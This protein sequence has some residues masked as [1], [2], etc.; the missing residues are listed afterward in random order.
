MSPHNKHQA[1]QRRD[2]TVTVARAAHHTTNTTSTKSA[3]AGNTRRT[4]HRALTVLAAAAA[5]LVCTPVV[6]QADYEQV[7]HFAT[8]GTE[9]PSGDGMAVN[10]TGAGGVEPG[11]LYLS[12]GFFENRVLRYSPAGELKEIWG[13]HTI[14]SGPDLPDQLNTVTVSATSGTYELTAQTGQAHGEFTQGSKIVTGVRTEVGALHV[15]DVIETPTSRVPT[16][17][18]TGNIASGSTTVMAASKIGEWVDGMALYAPG[19]PAGTTVTAVTTG[20]LGSGTLTLSKPATETKIGVSLHGR[21]TIAAVAAGTLE[22]SLPATLSTSSNEY[23]ESP[24][25]ATET[26]API[27]Y[28]ASAA[29]LKAALVALVAFE[30][31]DL[32]VT[33]GLGTEGAALYQLGFEGAYAGSPVPL[34]SAEVTLAGGFPSSSVEI[35][36]PVEASTSGFQ[37]CRLYAGD[38]CTNQSP[39]SRGPDA[40]GF[41]EP[42]GVAVDQKTGYVYVLNKTKRETGGEGEE[43]EHNLIEVFSADGSEV[44]ARFGD[45]A[46]TQNTETDEE[47]EK[48]HGLAARSIAVDES[49][50]VYVGDGGAPYRVM[51]FRPE[52]AGV[53]QEYVY[54]GA[55]HDLYV[56]EVPF[57]LSLD[58]AG[59]LYVSSQEF[60]EE[61][62]LGEPSAPPICTGAPKGDLYAMTVDPMTGELFY[63]NGS[64]N[65]KKIYRLKSCDPA[66]GQFVQ[67]QAPVSTTPSTIGIYALVFNPDLAWASGRPR[68]VLYAVDKERYEEGGVMHNGTG[69]VFAPAEVQAP[70]VVSES[71]SS[72]R[73][74]SAALHGE[75][76][77]DGFTTHYVFQYLTAAEYEA[78][79]SSERFAGA[80]EVPAHGGEI[81]SGAVGQAAAAVAGL[82]PDTAYRFRV[83]ATSD[84]NVETGES[85]VVQGEAL[86]FA[87]YPLYPP[88]LPDRRAYELVSPAQKNGGEVLPAAPVAGRCLYQCKPYAQGAARFPVQSSPDGE[89]L[90]Y[91]GLPFTPFEGADEYDS[92]VS[93]RTATGWRTTAL[94]PSLPQGI[95]PL[96]FDS[97]LTTDLRAPEG[98]NALELQDTSDPGSVS[99]L[100]IGSR[101]RTPGALKLSYGGATADFSR[102][103]FSANDALTTGSSFAPVPPDPDVSGQDLYESSDGAL[104]LLN[105]LPANA[106]VA[107]GAVFASLSPDTHAVSE[108]G[109]RVYWEAAGKL[110]VREDGELTREVRHAGTFLTASG[111]GSQVLLSDGCLYSLFTET[112]TDLTEGQGGFQGV[113]GTGEEGGRLSH[114]YFVDTAVLPA[115]EANERGQFAQSGQDNLYSWSEGN[116]KFVATLVASDGDTGSGLF[117]WAA[118]PGARTAEASRNGRFLAFA[119][120]AGLTGYDNIGPCGR[121]TVNNQT[122]AVDGSCAEAFLYDSATGRLACASCDPTGAAPLG[123]TI[124]RRL[125]ESQP[126]FPQPRYLTDEGRL[127]FDSA[128]SLSSRDDNEGVEDVYEYEPQGAGRDG[129]CERAA[130]CIFL[131]SSGT[132]TVDSN[133]IAVDETGANVFFDTRDQLVPLEDKDELLDIYDARE[134]GGISSETEVARAECQGESCQAPASPPSYQTP[135]SVSFAGAGNIVAPPSPVKPQATPKSLTRAQKLAE[136]LKACRKERSQSKRLSCEKR[137][138]MRFGVKP[139]AKAKRK[140]GK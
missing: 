60:I 129:T 24:I 101:Y 136:A 30:A 81:G 48:I 87:T 131:I 132:S 98:L 106:A 80:R 40:V 130:G 50:K 119:S 68:G 95:T 34:S 58:D 23:F 31:A 123:E 54:C 7:A 85:C 6:A 99:P 5:M 114:V 9:L 127:Y 44:I 88:G 37:R 26:T 65:G 104:S 103:F 86:S 83:V 41:E 82:S 73:T 128:D 133:L 47:P 125:E 38:R 19:V 137:A 138:R 12:D 4:L 20:A 79:G 28:N 1:G 66:V 69:F 91:T 42:I 49:G 33:G 22:L 118:E 100:A 90:A 17:D 61:R 140:G 113:A 16:I 15:G 64:A 62:S 122:V 108:D 124:L 115:A 72:I 3:H 112:C 116:L 135:N 74:A 105:V 139:K 93:R 8:E 56:S 39:V 46:A 59:H 57:E 120:H 18:A 111:D 21:T 109:R 94:I 67:A 51:C 71:V 77:P 126:W 10:T 97:T 117:D 55:S 11:S 35:E 13:L 2:T 70:T 52:A 32:S 14:A 63:F 43:R 29:T 134:G 75:I 76:N 36:T 53:Y 89:A 121:A 27:P 96:A 78:N 102:V 107:T 84:C 25:T 92:Y 110:Y 45:A